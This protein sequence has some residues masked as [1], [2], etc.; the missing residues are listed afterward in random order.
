MLYGAKK[1]KSQ[2][3]KHLR[4]LAKFNDVKG[5]YQKADTIGHIVRLYKQTSRQLKKDKNNRVLQF[6]YNRFQEVFQI[7]VAVTEKTKTFD[8]RLE[9]IAFEICRHTHMAIDVNFW[10]G[11]C[12]EIFVFSLKD[13]E[14]LAD[15]LQIKKCQLFCFACESYLS[16]NDTQ[17]ILCNIFAVNNT[18]SNVEK[19]TALCSS[20]MQSKNLE[21]SMYSEGNFAL[22]LEAGEITLSQKK[23]VRTDGVTFC[24]YE[25]GRQL[26]EKFLYAKFADKVSLHCKSLGTIEIRQKNFVKD[27]KVVSNV[28]VLNNSNKARNINLYIF[29]DITFGISNDFVSFVQDGIF[30]LGN[31]KKWFCVSSDFACKYDGKAQ[32]G[33][34]SFCCCVTLKLKSKGSAVANFAFGA[35]DDAKCVSKFKADSGN[36]D[37]F[38]EDFLYCNQAEI[39]QIADSVNAVAG[40]ISLEQRLAC[41]KKSFLSGNSLSPIC[42]YNL[43]GLFATDG[44]TFTVADKLL[45]APTFGGDR[46]YAKIDGK[47]FLLNASKPYIKDDVA[48]YKTHDG[49]LDFILEVSHFCEKTFTVKC[50][51]SSKKSKTLTVVLCLDFFKKQTVTS[52]GYNVR[53]G[54]VALNCSQEFQVT[55]SATKFDKF[56]PNFD[57]STDLTMQDICAAKMQ[58]KAEKECVLKFTLKKSVES[59]EGLSS[60]CVSNAFFWHTDKNM[61][62]ACILHA[63]LKEISIFSL[64]A[65][66]YCNGKYL[67]DI[68]T[69]VLANNFMQTIVTCRGCEKSVEVSPWAF[70][71]GAVWFISLYGREIDCKNLIKKTEEILL[72]NTKT[73]LET[74]A[75]ALCLKKIFP[76]AIDKARCL[77]EVQKLTAVIE[78]F[79]RKYRVFAKLCGVLS[80]GRSGDFYAMLKEI[81][82]ELHGYIDGTFLEVVLLENFAG[83]VAQDGNI[84]INTMLS[85]D[86]KEDITCRFFG[87][88]FVFKFCNNGVNALKING[89]EFSSSLKTDNLGDVNYIDIFY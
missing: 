19:T 3:Q 47:I 14:Q 84:K 57:F 83:I 80:S 55:S 49:N 39:S 16:G 48:I 35:F 33:I 87:K 34:Y 29:A 4:L 89:K 44:A 59:D 66:A 25:N 41:N 15:Y 46:V 75:K 12:R 73:P 86:L 62:S 51:N 78:S 18:L 54:G 88:R 24:F 61:L 77:T 69:E 6:I 20:Q 71:L 76:Y 28:Q 22:T 53:F 56:N 45:T 81:K 38:A 36:L 32:N 72:A 37:F 5:V 8:D 79:D 52:D 21:A 17:Q 74:I 58:T 31:G 67:Y 68:L 43:D 40:G 50:K 9:R 27:G 13:A 30:V 7:A 70:A 11:A 63:G 64:P 23:F 65:T 10:L 42:G 26:G 60:P 85:G 82:T 1:N 2:L